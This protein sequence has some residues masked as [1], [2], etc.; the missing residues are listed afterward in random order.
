[1]ILKRNNGI[2]KSAL[3]FLGL[4][5]RKE[6][7]DEV[8]GDLQELYELTRK[9]RSQLVTE[10]II[11]YEV[12]HYLRPFAIR[13]ATFNYINPV[14]MYRSYLT[15]AV[16]SMIKNRL[17]AF[18]NITGLSVGM[19][20]S[21]IIALWIIDELTF[22]KHFDNYSRVG[23]VLQNV[24]NNGEVQTWW[25]LP[26][27]LADELRKNYGADFSNIVLSSGLN[28][29]LL[30]G[31]EKKL[32]KRGL[33]AEPQF[34]KMFSLKMVAGSADA[35][36]DQS[37]ILLSSST[38]NALLGEADPIGAVLTIDRD[39]KMTVK[40]AGVYAD[41]PSNSEFANLDFVASWDL[42]YNASPW[43]RNMNDPW[44]PNAFD[45]YVHLHDNVTFESASTRIR[46]AKL[47][48]VNEALAKK[49]PALFVHP[50]SKWHL[51]AQ[52]NNGIQKGGR[53]Q[54]VWLFGI[55]GAFV[56]LMAC[57]N[58]M[59]LS[60][61]RSE[62]RSKEIGI[63]KAIGSFRA[64]LINQFFTESIL[65][66]FLSF[67][68]ALIIVML[69]LPTFNIIAEKTISLQWNNPIW[70]GT[71]IGFCILIGIIA[72]SYPA[73][74]LSSIQSVKA[75]KGAYKA[76][77]TSSVFRKVL[78]TLQF[79]VSVVLIIATTIVFQQIQ[80]AK[81][82][83]VGYDTNGLVAVPMVS[84]LHPHFDAVKDD[85]EKNGAITGMA[86][87]ASLTTQ[88]G[89]STS[90]LD[91]RGKDPDLSVDFGTV[92]GSYDYGT[93]VGW[94]I[95]AGRDFSRDHPSDSTVLILNE[96]A[97]NYMGLINPIGETIRWSG[98][99]YLVIGVVKD[100]VT[101]SPYEPVTPTLYYL[102]TWSDSY[103]ILRINPAISAAEALTKIESVYKKYNSEVPF[104]YEFM[105]TAYALK[106][107]N[108]ERI[109]TL[110]TMFTTLAIFISC[111]GIFGLS[112]FTAEQR[113]KEI[114]IRKVMGASVFQLWR[115]ISTDFVVLVLLSSVIAIP[116][117]YFAASSWLG[118]YT[119]HVHISWG[120]FAAAVAA[121]V[122]ISIIT[123]SWHTLVAAGMNPVK[124]LKAD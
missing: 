89:S 30:T 20:V 105:D 43:I 106:F 93:T 95:L 46:D 117:A 14:P 98:R 39:Q 113:M 80:H 55:T 120:I 11:W 7:L 27:P 3:T 48:K 4:F 112:S 79:T 58:F 60:T 109:A 31:D 29:H 118:H 102:S 22:E 115:L 34:S 53:I 54:Y 110:S 96:A 61:A 71:G 90:Q 50:M 103:L 86:Q 100:M 91:W 122:I 36:R 9:K 70:S 67:A 87:S 92:G 49:K 85:L 97:V 8:T 42:L 82:R 40:V 111:L 16:R 121:T 116:V 76:G 51:Y 18:I 12:I 41:M 119:Y 124:T 81:N 83:P 59:N 66:A 28:R 37:S 99:S 56:L 123:V 75:I 13:K 35:L 73:L 33:F 62:K 23:R 5:L 45:I 64:Q 84:E 6:L 44:R 17:H 57:I 88:L 2:P 101:R 77:R 108:E 21:I 104:S 25:S 26:W 1:L 114:G 47:K 38:A 32:S 68:M 63:R 19:A 15:T 74:Y 52:F 107:G 94:E 72:G 10:L 78:V 24:T 69:F 65:T